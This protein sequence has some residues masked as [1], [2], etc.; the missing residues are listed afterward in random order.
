MREQLCILRKGE[1]KLQNAAQING[2]CLKIH[3]RASQPY[4]GLGCKAI[5]IDAF[6]RRRALLTSALGLYNLR[7]PLIPTSGSRLGCNCGVFL[8]SETQVSCTSP[9][10][11]Q[12]LACS[13]LSPQAS[14]GGCVR[15]IVT[16]AAPAS[17]T[18]LG[19]LRAALGCQVLPLCGLP[20]GQWG[21]H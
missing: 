15:M 2:S 12:T 11:A 3:K 20:W 14:L 17:P 16:G 8:L 7:L 21:V 4:R 19:F 18:V 10:A 6:G 1:P 5:W 13:S 9:A